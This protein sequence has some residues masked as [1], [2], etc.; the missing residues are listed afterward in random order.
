MATSPKSLNKS[1]QFGVFFLILGFSALPLFAQEEG[2]ASPFDSIFAGQD[3]EITHFAES[4]EN[5]PVLSS[6]DGIASWAAEL[7]DLDSNL[8]VE[9]LFTLPPLRDQEGTP[10]PQ[11]QVRQKIISALS[12]IQQLKGLEYFSASRQ[13][14]RLLFKQAF[15]APALNQEKPLQD[16]VN[17]DPNRVQRFVVF[18]EDLTFGKNYFSV[19]IKPLSEGYGLYL[20]NLNAMWYGIL[21]LVD[22]GNLLMAVRIGIQAEGLTFYGLSAVKTGSFFGIENSRQDSFYNRI[23]ALFTWFNQNL[24]E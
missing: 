7:P 11:D 5:L 23:K 22:E 13:K 10:L 14:M 20:R 4:P 9:V 3:Q 8:N 12:Q 15:R 21:P 2:T 19:L 1:P 17:P 6:W 24:K 18:Q 16:P